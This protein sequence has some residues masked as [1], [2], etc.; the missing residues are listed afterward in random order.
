MEVLERRK[1]LSHVLLRVLL[2]EALA[3]D[4]V[5]KE[6]AASAQLHHDVDEAVVDVRLVKLDDVGVVSR[7]QNAHFLLELF[8]V[9]LECLELD[10]FHRVEQLRVIFV[11]REAHSAKLAAS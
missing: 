10:R 11:A 1:H 7:L 2:I 5:V 6:F 3:S 8:H 4:N 9:L